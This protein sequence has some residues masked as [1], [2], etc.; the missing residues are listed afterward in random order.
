MKIGMVYRVGLAALA[1]ITVL[2]GGCETTKQARTVAPEKGMILQENEVAMLK[3]GTGKQALLNY[4]NSQAKWASYKKVMVDPVI[5]A[6]PPNASQNELADL[7]KL[8]TNFHT[9]LLKELGQDYQV[10]NTPQPDTIRVQAAIFNPREK[11]VVLNTISSIVPISVGLSV[12]K[13]FATGKPM[14]V[15]EI[16]V[17]GRFTDAKSGELLAAA[18]DRRVGQKYSEG[19]F[20]SWAE[21]N[22]AMAYWAK[23][24]RFVLCEMR[25]GTDC[26]DPAA[27]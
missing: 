8:V 26:V 3:E 19:M 7:Q 20:D 16:S 1:G 13:D 23:R 12:I 25:G 10:V 27:Q 22:S 9:M 14:A 6:Q 4:I 21:A 2:L 18:V 11:R 24:T 15:G 5:M 17:E